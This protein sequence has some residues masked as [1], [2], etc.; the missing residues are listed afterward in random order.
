[1]IKFKYQ[2]VFLGTYDK[3]IC[4]CLFSLFLEKIDELKIPKCTFSRINSDNFHKKY[5]GNQ[6][7]FAIYFGNKNKK[8]KDLQKIKRLIDDGTMILPIYF[9]EN[10]FEEQVPV[11]L[12]KQNGMVYEERKNDKIVNLILEAFSL[13]RSSRKIFISYKRSESS[14][15][16]IQLYEALEKNNFDAF[17]DIHSIL[18]GKSFQDELW[19]SMTDCDT[20]IILNTPGFLSSEWCKEEIAEANSKQIGINSNSMA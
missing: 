12:H 7:T 17:L 11:C 4:D 5:N 8:F 19:N 20:I 14:S 15:V 13:L 10:N 18:P 6:P 1:M 3:V 9:T 16:A 2:V